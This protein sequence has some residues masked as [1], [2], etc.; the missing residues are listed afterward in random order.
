M[1]FHIKSR[2]S[3]FVIHHGFEK[4]G[5]FSVPSKN[6]AIILSMTDCPQDCMNFEYAGYKTRI[7]LSCAN[8]FSKD[9]LVTITARHTDT[10]SFYSL[11]LPCI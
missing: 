2:I 10:L 5:Y 6:L 8:P 9:V 3:H 7:V 4:N 11:P 1:N